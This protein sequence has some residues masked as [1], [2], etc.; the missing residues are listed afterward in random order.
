MSRRAQAA[1]QHLTIYQG[2]GPLWRSHQ[3]RPVLR[4]GGRV[5]EPS[6][7][8]VRWRSAS[9]AS[10]AMGAK[11]S[12]ILS[13]IGVSMGRTDPNFRSCLGSSAPAGPP[14]RLTP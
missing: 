11:I 6:C 1:G 8:L 14:P 4:D 3:D 10:T 2:M 13:N 9:E 12:G 7:K 5:L